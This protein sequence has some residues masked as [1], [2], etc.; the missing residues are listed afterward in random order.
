MP[1]R[2]RAGRHPAR[3]SARRGHAAVQGHRADHVRR[4][5]ARLRGA[6]G[7]RE[8]VPA[9]G[10]AGR[11]SSCTRSGWSRR[12]RRCWRPSVTRRLIASVHRRAATAA[13]S[14]P[15]RP[16]LAEL[17][18]RELEVL[19]LL[20]DGL[21]NAE[22][23]ARLFVGEA[24]V[25]T[26]VAR[27]L[28]KLGVRD[29]VQAVIVGLPRRARRP[30]PRPRRLRLGDVSGRRHPW[31]RTSGTSAPCSSAAKSSPSAGRR[32][33]RR[34]PRRRPRAPRD[35]HR[36]ADGRGQLRRRPVGPR[37][38]RSPGPGRSARRG[39]RRRRAG[40]AG[41]RG[42]AGRAA[43]RATVCS[44]SSPAACPRPVVDRLEAV[45]VD[46]QQRQ[47]VRAAARVPDRGLDL[48]LEPA[49]V[50]QPGERVG[51]GQLLDAG[52]AGRG[53]GRAPGPARAR[54]RR[55]R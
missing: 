46:E 33:S 44:S 48:L 10:R 55:A 1:R 9:Q 31:R 47:G 14:R 51:V 21:S 50:G 36:H 38:P 27:V 20:A 16:G 52:Q 42:A 6:A 3:S 15:P 18:A 5:R 35:L 17:T 7:R 41:R 37:R 43:S 12:A 32:R 54:P 28:M 26:H 40:R 45:E 2:G 22:I 23:A 24:T 34:W 53:C 8:R 39:T 13:A 19:V 25:K 11:T 4:R 49:P 29:R 30:G